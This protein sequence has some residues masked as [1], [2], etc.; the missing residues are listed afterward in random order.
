M[1]VF[2]L[3]HR[4]M[5]GHVLTRYL[6][7]QGHQVLTTEERYR[8]E[9]KDPFISAVM[10]SNAEWVVNAIGKIKQKCLE[11]SDLMLGNT[12]LPIHLKSFLTSG[13]RLIH[14]STDCVFSGKRGRY[15]VDDTRDAE[16]AYGLSKLLGEVIAERGV[17]Q[18]IRTSI[19]G[20]ETGTGSG[21]MGWFL[22]QSR[23][24]NGYTNHFWNGITTLQWAK[25]CGGIIDGSLIPAKGILQLAS[26]R[27]VSKQELLKIIAAV[28]PHSISINAMEAPERI[29][30]TLEPDLACPSIEEQMVEL[31]QWY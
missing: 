23:P 25:I 18:I 17:C 13:Q 3:G 1:K 16:D 10:R 6:R 31:R 27:P 4:G 7:E 29:D 12:L 20:P 24:V 14:A 26:D 28:W 30:R 2:V 5:L 21:L 15:Q 8:G 19:I 22:S 9:P 11:P